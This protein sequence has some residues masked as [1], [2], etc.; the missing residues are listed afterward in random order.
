ME[1]AEAMYR[2]SALSAPLLF[3]NA[4]SCGRLALVDS[5]K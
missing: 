3:E 5:T 1:E 4:S 2:V